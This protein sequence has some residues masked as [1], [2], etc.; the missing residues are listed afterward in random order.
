[1]EPLLPCPGCARHVRCNTRVCPF[2][3]APL[4]LVA[5][6]RLPPTERL[7]RAAYF[8]FGAIVAGSTA[9]CGAATGLDGLDGGGDAGRAALDAGAADAG[10]TDGGPMLFDAGGDGPLYGAPPMDAG[11]D[12]GA[13]VIDL[14]G[15]PPL[16]DAGPGDG[17]PAEAGTEALYGGPPPG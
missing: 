1:M 5:P 17:G 10:V 7:G 6:C 13:G 2:C 9:G 4:A 12:A 8:A 16:L 3:A 14:Y 15:G 11:F